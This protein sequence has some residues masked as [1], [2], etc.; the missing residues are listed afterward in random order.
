MD[1]QKPIVPP[2]SDNDTPPREHVSSPDCWCNPRVEYV[3]PET[4]VAV[5]VHHKPN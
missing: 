3:D 5:Y 1:I 4:G 2:A